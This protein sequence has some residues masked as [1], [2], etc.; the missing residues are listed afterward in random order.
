MRNTTVL[1]SGASVAG[2]A[3]AYWLNRYGFQVTVVEKAPALRTGGQAID[4]TG[5]THM[6]VLERMGVLDDIKRLQT[7]KTD[8][9]LIDES[10]AE[11]AV[12]SGDFLGGDIEILR[13]DLAQILYNHTA[14]GC[15]YLF[16][17]TVTALRETADGVYV[18]FENAPARVF[19]LVF[20]CD[21]MHSRVRKLAFGPE[22]DFVTHDGYYYAIAGASVWQDMPEGNRARAH[23]LT[24]NTPGLLA[25]LGGN[26]AAQMYLFASPELE[27]SRDDF[28]EQRRIVAEKFAGMG[29]EVPRMLAELP[30]LDGF[31]L[32]AIAK[33]SMKHFTNGRV[34]LIGDAAHGH[35]LN[36]FGTGSAIV[37]AY[38]MAG[39]LAV[40]E[41]DYTV[42]FARY[43]EIMKR[44]L[45]KTDDANPGRFMAPRTARGLRLRNWFVR[46][47]G[48]K[49]MAK[50]AENAKNDID[51]RNYPELV[52]AN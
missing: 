20:G 6:T 28:D 4:F 51:L 22:K 39:E 8:W 50:Y 10:G 45:R 52:S 23:A 38:V 36:G 34:A 46:S 37:G 42:A 26:K 14:A 30:Y 29:W 17:D 31:Y 18:E 7:G 43:E 41:G 16:G 21:G 12:M 13:G 44:L 1:I 40:A 47:R 11:Q 35:T 24:C 49:M 33:V 15:E 3:L 5:E 2:P 48:F 32:D 9:V 27:Y 25:Q 19:D